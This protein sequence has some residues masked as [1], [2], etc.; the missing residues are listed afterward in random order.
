MADALMRPS[1]STTLRIRFAV[2]RI[3]SRLSLA[4]RFT[5]ALRVLRGCAA[6][7]PLT[8]SRAADCFAW[9]AP[10]RRTP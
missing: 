10:S 9:V 6:G 3:L 2:K 5:D 1:A 4:F 8:I 7:M